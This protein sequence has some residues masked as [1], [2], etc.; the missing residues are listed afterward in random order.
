MPPLPTPFPLPAPGSTGLDI[1]ELWDYDALGGMFSAFM[2]VFELA[3]QNAVITAVVVLG[4]IAVAIWWMASLVG[5]RD[6]T[7]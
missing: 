1:S 2:T 3:K 4:L 6:D 5:S 7:V